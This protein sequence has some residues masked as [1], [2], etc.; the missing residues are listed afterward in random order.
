M[1]DAG[2]KRYEGALTFLNNTVDR[3]TGTIVARATIANPDRS[4]L[5]G[6]FVHVRLH[7]ADQPSTVLVPQVALGSN[8]LGKY[9][10]SLITVR[11]SIVQSR[12]VRLRGPR[13]YHQRG[14]CR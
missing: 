12:L 5:P 10:M 2:A 14:D 11:P 13:C 3:S 7:V 6:E 1:P 8:Q 9:S 4:L